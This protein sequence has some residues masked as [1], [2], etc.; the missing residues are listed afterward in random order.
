MKKLSSSGL[1]GSGMVECSPSPILQ[2]YLKY[3]VHSAHQSPHQKRIYI[4]ISRRNLAAPILSSP[5]SPAAALFI[6][7]QVVSRR[8]TQRSLLC[9]YA[10][11]AVPQSRCSDAALHCVLPQAPSSRL[12]KPN[13]NLPPGTSDE[14]V[15]LLPFV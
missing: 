15:L 7:A 3:Q 14:A 1:T 6:S 2:M 12:Q 11:L 9:A 5:V 4:Y 8:R 10:P 13:R